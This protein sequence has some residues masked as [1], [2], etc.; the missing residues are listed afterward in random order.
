M[1]KNYSNV[2]CQ[3]KKSNKK[4]TNNKSSKTKFRLTRKTY[5]RLLAKLNATIESYVITPGYIGSDVETNQKLT[6]RTLVCLQVA[7]R[8]KWPKSFDCSFVSLLINALKVYALTSTP[9]EHRTTLKG[10]FSLQIRAIRIN[11]YNILALSTQAVNKQ[12]VRK[13]FSRIKKNSNKQICLQKT[14]Q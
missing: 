12:R 2:V 7:V 13:Q 10:H 11:R 4:A 5:F 3:P 6:L 1:Y 8:T 9:A 14:K